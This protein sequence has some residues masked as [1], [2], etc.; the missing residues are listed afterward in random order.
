MLM[1]RVADNGVVY[2]Y[3]QRLLTA[4]VRHGFSTRIGGISPA[5]FDSFN[6]GNPNGSDVQDDYDRIWDNYELFQAACQLPGGPPIRV[7]QAHGNYVTRVTTD[8][9]FDCAQK[10]DAIVSTDPERTISIRI[11]DCVPILLAAADGSAV[12]A[13]HAGWRGVVAGVIGR[14]ISALVGESAPASGAAGLL[15]A[16]GPCISKDAFEVGPE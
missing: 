13:G 12:A 1:R 3:S 16:I 15:A 14:A 10:A 2:Y 9:E 6:L 7:H 4:G 11:A 5:P 8:T